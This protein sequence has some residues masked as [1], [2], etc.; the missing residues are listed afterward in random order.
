MRRIQQAGLILAAVVLVAACGS[1]KNNNSAASA[2][3]TTAAPATTTTAAPT[4]TTT[5]ASTTTTVGQ[6]M[7]IT[8]D[9]GLH[10]LQVVTVNGTGF[11]PGE[12]DIGVNECADKG[13]NTM[14]G[15]CDLAGTKTVIPDASGNIT[16]QFTV[17]KGPFGGNNIVCSAAQ[18]CLVSISQL[19]ASPTES[20]S[21]DIAFSS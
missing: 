11:T 1:S 18:K 7:T 13:N 19:V 21:L 16:L 4:T 15:D 2:T 3:T 12:K 9:T 17:K 14:A 10:D 20:A 8:P 5:V 6:N